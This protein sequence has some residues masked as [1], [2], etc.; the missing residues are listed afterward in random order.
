MP[1][2]RHRLHLADRH[3]FLARHFAKSSE[4]IAGHDIG[5]SPR[6]AADRAND[7]V[8]EIFVVPVGPRATKNFRSI[9]RVVTA[10]A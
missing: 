4:V 2:R 10:S 3:V 5:S 7:S 6:A 9:T 1:K 8:D